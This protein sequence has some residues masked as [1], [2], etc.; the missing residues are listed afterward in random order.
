MPKK[1]TFQFS[2]NDL[3]N[4][5]KAI[6]YDKR[7]EVRQRATG[8]RLLHEGKSPKAVATIFSV[9]Q[10]TVYDWHHRW[11]AQGVEGLANRPKSGRPLKA[12]QKYVELLKEVVEQNP[13]ELGY[14]F[15]IWTTERLRLHL[16]AKTGI[17]LKR[18]QLRTVLKENGFVYRRPRHD[19]TN[20]QDAKARKAADEWLN[21]LKKRR[22]RRDR[23]ILYGRKH[24]RLVACPDGLLDAERLPATHSNTRTTTMAT[25]L[26]S[27]QL[28]DR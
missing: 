26:W 16:K 8:L 9:S 21:E 13:Q 11:Q 7:P 25:H 1:L 24:L 23:P 17:E 12:N 22:T 28:G 18:T 27:L 20:L 2:V 15:S 3:A 4:I 10:P 19:L 5:T 6:K 14:S